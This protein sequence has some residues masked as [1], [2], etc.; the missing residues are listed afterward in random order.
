MKHFDAN[1]IGTGWRDRR[2]SDFRNRS[3]RCR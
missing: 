1:I 3:L 2:N